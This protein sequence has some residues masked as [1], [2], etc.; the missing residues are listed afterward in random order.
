MVP[1]LAAMLLTVGL[2]TIAAPANA[3]HLED[4]ATYDPPTFYRLDRCYYNVVEDLG[5]GAIVNLV[6]KNV[7]QPGDAPEHVSDYEEHHLQPGA[8]YA[9][10]GCP[11]G[12]VGPQ[13]PHR[14]QESTT[15][16]VYDVVADLG[17]GAV[18]NLVNKNVRWP[19]DAVEH[20]ENFVDYHVIPDANHAY[21]HC[22]SAG[23][24]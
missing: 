21:K 8:G 16:C 3:S 13:D 5:E 9:V 4:P 17:E 6:N 24:P 12:A 10:S 7:R 19:E 11:H 15:R 22:T 2:A 23:L 20:G 1:A 18:I 14:N